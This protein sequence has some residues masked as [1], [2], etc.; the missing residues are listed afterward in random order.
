MPDVVECGPDPQFQ[1]T[2]S[3]T[4]IVVVLPPLTESR[5][6]RLPLGPTATVCAAGGG[7]GVAAAGGVAVAPTA[8]IVGVMATPG[9]VGEELLLLHARSR[10]R[11]RKT[12][13]AANRKERVMVTS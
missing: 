10:T 13:I 12:G 5:K 11:R 1:V 9:A 3:P 6:E 7:V 2:V 4:W 8:G